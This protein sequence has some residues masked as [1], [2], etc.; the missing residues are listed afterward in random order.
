MAGMAARASIA[1]STTNSINFFITF[2][3]KILNKI[4]QMVVP[5]PGCASSNGMIMADQKDDRDPER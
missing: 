3:P 4:T 1:R 5:E 2:L